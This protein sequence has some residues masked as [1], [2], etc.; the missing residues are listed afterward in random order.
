[1]SGFGDT[2]SILPGSQSH[3]VLFAYDLPYT[4]RLDLAL[5]PPLAVQAAVIIAPTGGVA[6]KSSQLTDGGERTMQGVNV[7][8]YTANSLTAGAPLDITLSGKVGQ[9]SLFDQ[10]NLFGL[11]IGFGAFLL[12]VLV[13]VMWYLR[14]RREDRPAAPVLAE[15]AR[16]QS[17]EGLL[18]AIV[19]LDDM[20][21]AGQI[22]Q[23]AYDQR[24]AELKEKLRLAQ[25]RAGAKGS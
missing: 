5:T 22:P 2:Q 16:A 21:Q 19:A 13:A 14:R 24:R 8:L 23:E 17:T 15:S 12:A 9:T 20:Y 6:V 18:D 1:D 10:S 4:D 11:I 7:H 25:Q 3:Q